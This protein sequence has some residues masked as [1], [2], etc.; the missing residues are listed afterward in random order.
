MRAGGCSVLRVGER[1][2]ESG[3]AKI[4]PRGEMRIVLIEDGRSRTPGKA[5][6]IIRDVV[7]QREHA[8]GA[9]ADDGAATNLDHELTLQLNKARRT[10]AH[11]II[12]I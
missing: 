2:R 6:R 4:E 7:D 3:D 5:F 12:L 9:V 1:L 11:G 10:R 8:L